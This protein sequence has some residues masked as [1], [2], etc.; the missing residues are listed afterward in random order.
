MKKTTVVIPNW[1]GI[2]Y[3]RVCLD[4]LRAQDTDDFE[5]LVIDNASAD[6]S[7][8]VV[9]EEYPEVRLARMPENLGF[10]GGVNEGIC[11][12]ETPYV[13]LLN[14]DIE[15]DPGFVRNMTMRSKRIRGFSR[16]P[17]G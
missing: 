14:N 3:I 10:S 12:T 2:D 6:G 1:N 5:V 8:L 16:F 7:D 13:L 17:H 11:R 9:E 15:C 4:S